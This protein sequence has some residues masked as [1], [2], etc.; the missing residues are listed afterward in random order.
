MQ[1]ILYTIFV[2]PALL[3]F[4]Y[5]ATTNLNIDLDYVNLD[6][7]TVENSPTLTPSPGWDIRIV[8]HATLI[9]TF[10]VEHNQPEWVYLAYMPTTAFN[11]VTWNDAMSAPWD[12]SYTGNA[13]QPGDVILVNTPEGRFFK[14]GNPVA[15]TAAWT[16][17]IEYEELFPPPPPVRMEYLAIDSDY[18][19]LD[20]PQTW[21]DYWGT[22]PY[23]Q[24]WDF[25]FV[26]D[27]ILPETFQVYP[28]TTDF[29]Y[30]SSAV[31]DYSTA[32]YDDAWLNTMYNT[33]PPEAATSG[34]VFFVQTSMGRVF[35][36]GNFAFDNY[37]WRMHFDFEELFPPPPPA[38]PVRDEYLAIESDYID[39]DMPQTWRDYW[40]TEPYGQPWD[41]RFV[42]DPVLPETFQLQQN[43]TNWIYVAHLV[44]YTYENVTWNDAMNAPLTNSWTTDP[45]VA[46]NVIIVQT[47]QGR[48]FKIGNAAFDNYT[49]RMHFDYEE[50]L[51]PPP[52]VR[53]AYLGIDYDYMDLDN[54]SFSRDEW[55]GPPATPWDIRITWDPVNTNNY[56]VEV[57]NSQGTLVGHATGAGY[58]SV[59]WTEAST[60]PLSPGPDTTPFTT[61]GTVIIQ[62]NQG[63][64]FKLGNPHFDSYLWRMYFDYEELFP[65][66]PPATDGWL[67]LDN[68]YLDLDSNT[69]YRDQ[70]GG[71]PAAPWDIKIAFEPVNG[72]GY[73]HQNTGYGLSIAHLTGRT[74]ASVTH[75]DTLTAVW[76]P[77]L[78]TT[79]FSNDRVVLVMTTDGRTFKLGNSFFDSFNWRMHFDFEELIPNPPPARD[80]YLGLDADYLDLDTGNVVRQ[81]WAGEPVD[82]WDIKINSN[83]DPVN[84]VDAPYVYTNSMYGLVIA[85]MPGADYT[86]VDWSAGMTANWMPGSPMTPVDAGMVVLVN[87]TD[88]RT[89]KLGNFHFD[90]F[91]WQMGF[92]YEELLPPPAPA[93]SEYLGFDGDYLDLDTGNVVRQYWAG[94]PTDPWD[95]KINSN[96]DPVNNVDAPYVYS[97]ASHGLSMAHLPG[98]DYATVGWNDVVTAAWVPGSPMTPAIDSNLVVLVNTTD[99]RTFKIGN[100][101]FDHYMWQMGFDYEEL[102]PPPAPARDEYLGLDGDY[103]DLDTGN[104][105]R[106]YWAG[107][108]TDPW[109]IKI[110]SN[111]DPVNNVDAPYVYSNSSYGLSMAHLP[112]ATYASVDWNDAQTA[113]WAPGS[114]M[115]PSIDPNL[116]VLINT[117]DGRT[118]KVG[119]FYF[120]QY[121]WQMGFDYEELLPPPAPSRDAYVGIAYDY[122]DLDTNTVWQDQ[123][124][125]P[126]TGG[127]DLRFYEDPVNF[128]T[129]YIELNPNYGLTHA[130]VFSAYS[131][132]TYNDAM[133]ATWTS[134]NPVFP[135]A[136]TIV[137]NTT[138]G[139]TFKLGNGFFDSYAWE[140]GFDYQE[141]SQ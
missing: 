53:D 61:S 45:V 50:L 31:M 7:N 33:T 98:A 135:N 71:E 42:T 51:P 87:T 38:P 37:T 123:F 105:V 85:H 73:V 24:P 107:E 6:T 41:F 2:F 8:P 122:V 9:D 10:V 132:V 18:I 128:G 66:A 95:I 113:A 44:G 114:P 141:L 23:G 125:G 79:A 120:D 34:R 58:A 78:D 124:S 43:Q 62:T 17:Q 83:W 102:L 28:N 15:N 82:P 115:T 13:F 49:W 40:G 133:A 88:G 94:E 70:W 86:S 63:R 108:P 75:T 80:E 104:V 57:N 30:V 92:D 101:Y 139:R 64:F 59:G 134:G 55:A 74:F 136:A 103:L 127:W 106:Q 109:D 14:L 84:N 32:T 22:Q 81:Y 131:T 119:N 130:E 12:N 72:T 129:F 138:D 47:E 29:T 110:Q 137:V 77:G 69:F 118:F 90:Q 46:G 65:P 26:A 112:G 76:N 19:D 100:F 111:W 117:T 36:V 48:Y 54:A 140:M 56:Y 89:F 68:D 60:T 126:P 97:N 99:G 1:R 67:A 121:M 25:R 4:A 39:L 116:V 5:G 52:P 3:S 35:K 96:W 91:S 93:R 20:M 11:A 16:F 21:R 27:P